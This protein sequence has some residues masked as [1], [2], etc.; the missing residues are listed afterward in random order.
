MLKTTSKD[1]VF[2]CSPLFLPF[3]ILPLFFTDWIHMQAFHTHRIF[4]VKRLS[5]S[6]HHSGGVCLECVDCFI[7][8]FSELL[9]FSYMLFSKQLCLPA[10]TSGLPISFPENWTPSLVLEP[11]AWLCERV[12]EHALQSN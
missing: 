11:A 2:Y 9:L 6:F 3:A 8:S 7:D 5:V 1:E 4:Q 10:H 12:Q